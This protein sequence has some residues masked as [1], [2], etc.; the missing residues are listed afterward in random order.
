MFNFAESKR[1][2]WIGPRTAASPEGFMFD[3]E[4]INSLI[5][6]TDLLAM[7]KTVVRNLKRLDVELNATPG[8]WTT[9]EDFGAYEN[10]VR[11]T[12]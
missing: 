2:L 11:P 4:C 7:I 9:G 12:H 8:I 10:A 5:Q 3:E 6:G 1:E